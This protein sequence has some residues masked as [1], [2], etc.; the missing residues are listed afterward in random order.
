MIPVYLWHTL[1]PLLTRRKSW[2]PTDMKAFPSNHAPTLSQDTGMTTS[3]SL[4]N[5]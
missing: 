1:V 4:A 5:I 3:W 2:S